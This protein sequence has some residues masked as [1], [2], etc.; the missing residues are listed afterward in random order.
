MAYI[1]INL[2]EHKDKSW[3]RHPTLSFAKKDTVAPVF[4]NEVALAL[5]SLPLAFVK[6]GERFVLVV[7]MGLK[8]GEN[9]L[10]SEDG[11]WLSHFLPATYRCSPFEL[12]E[13]PNSQEQV[14]C[15]DETRISNK[16][17]G[18]PFFKESG[19]ISESVSEAFDF[20]KGLYSA[21]IATQIACS[22]LSE[23]NLIMPWD[24][25]LDNDGEIETVNGLYKIDE[26]A[27]YGLTDEGFLDLRESGAIGVIYAQL[28]SGT[29]LRTLSNLMAEHR[30]NASKSVK[31]SGGDIF[32]FS[33]LN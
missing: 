31:K 21:R 9:L 23:H 12:I 14:L 33:G 24:V 17:V 26:T 30:Q 7:V 13:I 25:K 2:E 22:K 18:D 16:S 29:K 20:I 6:Q 11:K 32:D 4:I 28:F 3:V 8:P 27:L 15:I 10:V 19:E 5:H 1:P